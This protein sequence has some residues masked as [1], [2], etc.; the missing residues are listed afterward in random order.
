MKPRILCTKCESEL[1]LGDRF[2]G[3]CG[4]EVEWSGAPWG[5][6]REQK[7]AGK[8][9]A[10]SGSWKMIGG[11]ALF[12]VGGVVA[13]ELLTGN[14]QVP[15][16]PASDAAGTAANIQSLKHIEELETKANA[17]PTDTKARLELA[18]H[19]HDSRF[20][21]RAIA[22][23]KKYL[24]LKPDDPDALVDLGICFNDIGQTGEAAA[25]MQKALKVSP[26]HLLAHFNLGIVSLRAGDLKAANDW[27]KKTAALAP[28]SEVGKRAGEM[29][30]QHAEV[31]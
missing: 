7:E 6:K 19:L 24:E 11:L 18:N 12:L 21:D 10:Q 9:V 28:D 8:R 26:K 29:L 31:N 20:Y 16:V 14:R 25:W 30:R 23:Y 2:C 5:P 1:S 27:F 13:L 22:E 4:A 17:N 15:S 3:S